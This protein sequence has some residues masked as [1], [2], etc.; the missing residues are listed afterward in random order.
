MYS[1]KSHLSTCCPRIKGEASETLIEGLDGYLKT[2]PTKHFRDPW[3]DIMARLPPAAAEPIEFLPTQQ[4]YYCS[5]CHRAGDEKADRARSC[6]EKHGGPI[7]LTQCR[8]QKL[9]MKG[10][11]RYFAVTRPVAIQDLKLSLSGLVGLSV[12]NN[13]NKKRAAPV[14]Q[15]T[16][17]DANAFIRE[18]R[19]DKHLQGH[20]RSKVAEAVE[21]RDIKDDIAKIIDHVRDMLGRLR[22]QMYQ[23]DQDIVLKQLRRSYDSADASKLFNYEIFDHTLFSGYMTTVTRL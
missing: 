7:E 1:F 13:N 9:V 11:V 17:M 6:L 23:G 14:A 12:D 22:Q 10:A 21:H 15:I 8:G 2:E 4:V 20:D 19:F 16:R 18:A 3:G 5:T